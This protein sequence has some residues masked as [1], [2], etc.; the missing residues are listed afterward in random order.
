MLTTRNWPFDHVSL[1]RD[2]SLSVRYPF[3]IRAAKRSHFRL[4][5]GVGIASPIFSRGVG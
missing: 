4:N 1:P 5:F 2:L 3:G